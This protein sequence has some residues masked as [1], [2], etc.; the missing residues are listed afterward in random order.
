MTGEHFTPRTRSMTVAELFRFGPARAIVPWWVIGAVVPAVW[1]AIPLVRIAVVTEAPLLALAGASLTGMAGAIARAHYIHRPGAG[2]L[3][4]AALMLCGG[5]AGSAAA[6]LFGATMQ[7]GCDC[8]PLVAAGTP[9]HVTVISFLLPWVTWLTWCRYVMAGVHGIG[10]DYDPT[11]IKSFSKQ[12]MRI[13]PL[14]GI[15]TLLVTGGAAAT[16]AIQHRPAPDAP[17]AVLMKTLAR[18]NAASL[19]LLRNADVMARIETMR[20]MAVN[21]ARARLAALQLDAARP[22]V[23][24][25]ACDLVLPGTERESDLAAVESAF[26]Q[27]DAE[28]AYEFA[29]WQPS[30]ASGRTLL[31]LLPLGGEGVGPRFPFLWTA[32]ARNLAAPAREAEQDHVDVMYRNEKVMEAWVLSL[33]FENG[34]HNAAS[35]IKLLGTSGL[36]AGLAEVVSRR[37]GRQPAGGI[38]TVGVGAMCAQWDVD[39]ILVR[40]GPAIVPGERVTPVSP[41]WISFFDRAAVEA[42]QANGGILGGVF[43]ATYGCDDGRQSR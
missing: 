9:P 7:R 32:P 36:D 17:P 23:R 4:V 25:A 13:L 12:L 2:R 33:A 27:L 1:T 34:S 37:L 22:L 11:R 21:G 10:H 31:D 15:L 40:L 43:A 28:L 24:T 14:R 29:T 41:V 26:A 19:A 18:G 6:A 38:R 20:K 39:G 5:A 35:G 8:A 42:W 16:I 30:A 3:L